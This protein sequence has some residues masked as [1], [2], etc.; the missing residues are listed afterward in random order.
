MAK[1]LLINDYTARIDRSVNR[2]MTLG[3]GGCYY[4]ANNTEAPTQIKIRAA[5]TISKLST[6]TRYDNTLNATGYFKLRK[7]GADGNSTIIIPAATSGYFVDESGTDNVSVGDL[8]CVRGYTSATSGACQCKY[9]NAIFDTG[10]GNNAEVW[11]YDNRFENSVSSANRWT[12]I[13]SYYQTIATDT[14]IYT[15]VKKASTFKCLYGYVYYNAQASTS[16]GR[17]Y[18]QGSVRL[19]LTVPPST[20]GAFEDTGSYAAS[21]D[22]TVYLNYYHGS[23]T[24]YIRWGILSIWETLDGDNV[25]NNVAGRVLDI[26]YDTTK[27]FPIGGVIADYGS[28]DEMT[29][30]K[31]PSGVKISKLEVKVANNTLNGAATFTLMKNGVATDLAVS[32]PAG[33]GN[34]FTDNT[35]LIE[36]AAGDYLN[37]KLI[38]GGTSGTLK[39]GSVITL[40]EVVSEEP[41]TQ[42]S[43]SDSVA[44]TDSPKIKCL[45]KAEDS[46][47][48]ADSPALKGSLLV[49]DL[50][51]G[52]DAILIAANILASDS[53]SAA[54]ALSIL[55]KI[56]MQDTGQGVEALKILNILAINDSAIGEEALSVLL[57]TLT[58][59]SD[60]AL[61]EETIQ[62]IGKI[63]ATDLGKAKE[64]LK[65]RWTEWLCRT[66]QAKESPYQKK[67]SPY[68]KKKSPYKH[69]QK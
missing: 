2:F 28:E 43:V 9:L 12:S 31:L 38:T 65:A 51:T 53:G 49:S 66:Y 16:Y 34:Y 47:A 4:D 36:C 62:T 30:I 69:C 61:A 24:Q 42:I 54:E 13:S 33:G 21:V 50:G 27:Y 48:G 7:N 41:P 67:E 35:H 22:N 10:S 56:A 68:H 52:T 26:N 63:L 39:L 25:S 60:S 17:F 1:T 29:R 18:A 40:V 8:V 15:R 44:G 32:I 5:G 3:N 59:I 58:K 20:T 6:A 64:R 37:F 55:S 14:Y 23:G 19:T 45:I 46:G 57:K 11:H